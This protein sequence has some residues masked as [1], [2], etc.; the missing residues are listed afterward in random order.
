ME[1]FGTY[2][3][4]IKALIIIH[5]VS[6]MKKWKNMRKDWCKIISEF[7]EVSAYHLSFIE[8]SLLSAIAGNRKIKDLHVHDT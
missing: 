2:Q 8:V 6:L 1:S 4:N 3:K 5:V 7:S